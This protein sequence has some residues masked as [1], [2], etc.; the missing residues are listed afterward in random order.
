[1]AIGIKVDP[2]IVAAGKVVAVQERTERVSDADRAAGLVGKVERHDVLLSQP[3]GGQ[4][5]VRFRVRDKL[6]VPTPGEFV[7]VDASVSEGS[8]RGENGETI[9]F[10]SLVAVGPAYDALDAIQSALSASAPSGK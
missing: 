6:P 8:F 10:V 5:V 2:R 3:H 4:L 1:M 7:A 9:S